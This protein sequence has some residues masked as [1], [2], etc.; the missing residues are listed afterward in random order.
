[1]KVKKGSLSLRAKLQ[2]YKSTLRRRI[3]LVLADKS[4]QLGVDATVKQFPSIEKHLENLKE[5]VRSGGSKSCEDWTNEMGELMEGLRI[6]VNAHPKL[7][8]P[9]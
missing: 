3:R 2:R 4:T 1:M 6:V 5:E 9:K 8:W 7:K